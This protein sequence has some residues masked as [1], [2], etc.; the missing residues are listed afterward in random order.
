MSLH[1]RIARSTICGERRA[2]D[3]GERPLHITKRTSKGDVARPERL[4]LP[5]LGFE[6]RCSIQ[7][8]YGRV[9]AIVVERARKTLA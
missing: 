3:R 9:S 5:T 4:E 7:L 8:S 2:A 6:G 1:A